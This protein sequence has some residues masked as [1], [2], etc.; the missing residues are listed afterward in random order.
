VVLFSITEIAEFAQADFADPVWSF[1]ASGA[2][3]W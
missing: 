3:D 1:R 2:T